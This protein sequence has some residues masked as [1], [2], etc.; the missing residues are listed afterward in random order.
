MAHKKSDRD[1]LEKYERI[2]GNPYDYLMTS[3]SDG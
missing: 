1:E 3:V 2:H